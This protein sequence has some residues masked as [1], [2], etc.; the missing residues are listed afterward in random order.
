MRGGG[1]RIANSWRRCGKNSGVFF[2]R[3]NG[4]E[5]GNKSQTHL[6]YVCHGVRNKELVCVQTFAAL[7]TSFHRAIEM[8]FCVAIRTI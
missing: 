5:A 3:T 1:R 2:T 4:A 7:V 6:E 8:I